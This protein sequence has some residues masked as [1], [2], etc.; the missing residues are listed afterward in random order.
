[1]SLNRLLADIAAGKYRAAIFDIDGTLID[2]MPYWA[3]LD[4]QYLRTQ[5]IFLSPGETAEL[6]TAM[7]SLTVEEGVRYLKETFSLDASEEEIAAGINA[8]VAEDY[9]EKIPLR[10]YV[11]ELLDVLDAAGVPLGLATVGNTELET[12][13]LTR[14]GIYDRFRDLFNCSELGVTK[15]EPTI[16]TLAAK[17]LAGD[18]VD[19]SKVLVVEDVLHALTTAKGA[20]FATAAVEDAASAG[21][22]DEIRAI[23]DYYIAN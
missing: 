16:Y 8:I 15:R 21:Q 12:A 9:R 7:W 22:R 23:A 6:N 4:A 5:D 10:P 20:G 13:A 18:D 3:G 19:Y 17:A 1:M 11:P 2:S 14:L